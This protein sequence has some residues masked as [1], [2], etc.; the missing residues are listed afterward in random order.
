MEALTVREDG[1]EVLEYNAPDFPISTDY[2]CLSIFRDYAAGCHWHRDYE[3]LIALDAEMDY[4]VNG[5]TVHLNKGDAI[6]VNSGRLHYGYSAEMQECHYCFVVFHPELLGL[7]PA[8]A[9]VL[10]RLSS[11]TCPDFWLLSAEVETDRP[12][13]AAIRFLCDHA[14]PK[15]SLA[16][17]AACAGLLD[18]IRKR[19]TGP[20]DHSADPDWTVIRSMVGYIQ[21]HYQHRIRLE[22]I[23]GAGAVC[24]SRCCQLF[25]EKLH[26]T[27][28]NY[29]TRY[30]LDKACDLIREGSSITDA[31]FT[32]GFQGLSYFSESFKKY[33]GTTPSQYARN[34]LFR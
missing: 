2:S 21:N 10:E 19:N 28:M 29:L 16:V 14:V 30:R 15:E 4:Q 20:A 13:I 25:K 8:V 11:D 7:T 6:F 1:S 26:T 23:A 33:Y 34:P 18:E 24:R 31:A 32:V 3:A 27:P 9:S 17:I 22:E 5:K 12:A